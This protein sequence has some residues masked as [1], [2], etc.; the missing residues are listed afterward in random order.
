MKIR[1]SFALCLL[2]AAFVST[3]CIREEAANAECDIVGVDSIWLAAQPAGFI[4][5]NPLIRNNSVTFLVRK[6][7][8]RTHLNPAFYITPR[9][10][11]FYKDAAGKRPFDATEYHDFTTPQTYVVVSEDGAWEKEYKVSFEDPQPVDS[12]DFEHFGYDERSQYQ[13]LYQTQTD[14]SL[15][16]NIWASGNGGFALT[17]MAH[18]PEDYPTTF[19]DGGVKGRCAKLE[20]KSTGSFG[21]RVKMPIAAG[22]L[23]IGEFKVAQAMLYPLKAT[24]FGL[25]LV[26]SEPLSLSGYY[27]YK[28]GNTMTDKNG[29][30]LAGRKDT[31]DIYAVLYEVDPTHFVPLQGDDVLSNPRIVSIAR[32]DNP[33]EPEQWTHFNTPFRYQT[34][35]SFDAGRMRRNGYAIAVVMT[36]SRQG[37]FFEG[38]VGS[39][40]Y[41]D[42]IKITWKQ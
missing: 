10:R 4:T 11:L 27:K 29:Q 37:A 25:Q 17:G 36:S 23:F 26:K 9:A 31:C 5:G 32:L 33:G 13:I 18:T 30:V 3:S 38:A 12:T 2:L 40:L 41:L 39:T 24:R 1:I 16:A 34:G 14:G 15:N 22:N 6:N 20:T 7:A 28:A 8:D 21:S 42:N 19:I 35:K